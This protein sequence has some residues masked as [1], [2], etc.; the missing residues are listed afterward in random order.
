MVLGGQGSS[1]YSEV[2][3]RGLRAEVASGPQPVTCGHR[4]ARQPLPS[5]LEQGPA[6]PVRKGPRSLEPLLTPLQGTSRPGSPHLQEEAAPTPLAS[7]VSPA[8]GVLSSEAKGGT[9]ALGILG[10]AGVHPCSGR[11]P[12]ACFNRHRGP[13]GHIPRG[14]GVSTEAVMV[15]PSSALCGP[16]PGTGPAPP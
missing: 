3:G 7:G 9:R 6:S 15:G 11:S 8:L 12:G 10:L 4:R 2:R 5:H 16:P 13:R 14:P 1:L